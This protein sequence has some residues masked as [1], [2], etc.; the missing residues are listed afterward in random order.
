MNHPSRGEMIDEL[1]SWNVGAGIV[2]MALFPFALPGI[3]LAVAAALPLLALALPLVLIGGIG[4]GALRFVHAIGRLVEGFRRHE[5]AG[6]ETA[7]V[8]PVARMGMKLS[9]P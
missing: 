4:I 3:V 2:T 5:P 7:P 6:R 1:S 8:R 9:R